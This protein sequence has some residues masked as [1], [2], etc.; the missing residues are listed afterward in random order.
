MSTNKAQHLRL[1]ASLDPI[2]FTMSVFSRWS[3]AF[4]FAFA[5][6]PSRGI[7]AYFFVSG[8]FRLV[9]SQFVVRT[10]C[11]AH[12]RRSNPLCC[13]RLYRGTFRSYMDS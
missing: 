2:A 6:T 11:L 1:C 9:C 13:P 10:A 8:S 7:S 5:L 4:A 12:R 3:G